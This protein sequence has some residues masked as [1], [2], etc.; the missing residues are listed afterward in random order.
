[1]CAASSLK[2]FL[3]PELPVFLAQRGQ[4]CPLVAGGLTLLG[5][6]AL[7]LAPSWL[8]LPHRASPDP[9]VPGRSQG[10]PRRKLIASL[11]ALLDAA[12]AAV[13][14]RCCSP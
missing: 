6:A 13:P 9:K 7:E 1:M 14:I 12:A 3:P 10:H 8:L 4:F 5:R 2:N 11:I